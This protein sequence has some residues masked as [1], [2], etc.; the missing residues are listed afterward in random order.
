[1]PD[2]RRRDP[3]PR[4]ALRVEGSAVAIEA[5]TMLRDLCLLAELADPALVARD[6]MLTLLPGERASIALGGGV[7]SASSLRAAVRCANAISGRG[8][9]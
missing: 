4:L 8:L 6:G 9:V 3:A 7:A 2:A 5:E 1:V